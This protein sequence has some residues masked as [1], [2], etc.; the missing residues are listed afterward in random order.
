MTMVFCVT[1]VCRV[2]GVLI[3][4]K[5]APPWGCSEFN[6]DKMGACRLPTAVVLILRMLASGGRCYK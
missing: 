3:Q 1:T 6:G 2:G 5:L 4:S